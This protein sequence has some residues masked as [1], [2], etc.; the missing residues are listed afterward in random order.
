MQEPPARSCVKAGIAL[1]G[2]GLVALAPVPPSPPAAATSPAVALATSYADLFANTAD[3]LRNIGANTDWSAI[4][5]VFTAL[6]TNPSGV[7]EAVSAFTMAV[8][9]DTASLPATVSVQLSPA[10]EL[11]I[12]SLASRMATLDAMYGVVT[13][14]ADPQTAFSALFNAPATV[15]DAYLNGQH[16]LN[17]LNGIITI[18]V[19]HGILAPMQNLEVELDLAR[20][21]E[22]L[23]LGE[24]DLSSVDLDGL[25]EQLRL[26]TLTLGGL[27]SGLGVS[28]IGLG[29]LLK[30]GSN[31]S[32]L[33]GLLDLLG[34]G[35]F[36]LARYTLPVILDELGL[37][38]EIFG[39]FD[40]GLL[41]LEFDSMR[42]VDV[43]SAVGV[44]GEIALG[45]GQL[46]VGLGEGGLADEGVGSALSEAGLLAHILNGLNVAVANAFDPV[47][48]VGPLLTSLVNGLL[49]F[50]GVAAVL[51]NT[52]IGDL[53]GNLGVD[54][55]VG[56]LLRT[57]G[58]AALS[59]GTLTV[60]ELL[61]DIGFADSAGDL[62]LNDLLGGLGGGL[63]GLN[64]TWLLNGLD[65]DGLVGI[66][67]LDNLALDFGEAVRDWAGPN[68]GELLGDLVQGQ[69]SL[70]RASIGSF[71]GM[72]TEL[73]VS[74]PQQLLAML[75]G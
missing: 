60:G 72:V 8:D 73:F 12:A 74:V 66:L 32:D 53:L 46:L 39:S 17:L 9:T 6:L 43:L 20:L 36:G 7:I 22:V 75:A 14:L 71:G 1:A 24:V 55:S 38:P 67:G 15:L 10:F 16:N 44:D 42:L 65:L 3:N 11:L 29:D 49:G 4:S 31:V 30:L 47:P 68:V 37:D 41:N 34:L 50:D 57:L 51:N 62:T 54:E 70:A 69:V 48:L 45:L 40:L 63:L 56:S 52:T 26:G 18:P 61:K 21:L 19:Y 25:T 33:G 5:Q 23:G 28:D 59:V 64:I 2:V 27:F 35:D 13:D 58:G